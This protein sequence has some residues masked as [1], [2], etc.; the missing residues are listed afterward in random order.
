MTWVEVIV[1]AYLLTGVSKVFR[2]F[3]IP[4]VNRPDYIQSRNLLGYFLVVVAWLPLDLA[5]FRKLGVQEELR[6]NCTVFCAFAVFG[7]F[8]R[9]S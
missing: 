9:I 8:A 6:I 2:A 4:A 7:Y 1:I 5:A 3:T